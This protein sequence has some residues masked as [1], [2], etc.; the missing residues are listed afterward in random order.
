M[1]RIVTL[2]NC[3]TN[4]TPAFAKSYLAF[5]GLTVLLLLL[6]TYYLLPATSH[7]QQS[8]V[9]SITPG[10]GDL[11]INEE[12]IVSIS[13]NSSTGVSGFDLKF[14][15]SG[16]LLITDFR[17]QPSFDN[18]FDLFNARTV[19]REI[20]GSNSR[21]SYIFTASNPQ[22]PK[23]VTIYTKIK[24]QSGGEGKINLDYNNSQVLNGNGQPMQVIP[25]T[26]TYNLNPQQ[27][28]A[29]FIDLLTLPPV[30]YP[31]TAAVIDLKLKLAGS[32]INPK[33]TSIKALAVAVGRIGEGKYETQPQQFDLTADTDGTFS[34]KVAF[35]DFKDGNKFSLM[36]KV[37]KYLLKRICNLDPSEQKLGAYSCTEPA[38]TIR[39]GEANAF[40]FSKVSLL[41]GDLGLTDGVLNGYDLNIVRMNLN[42]NTP[43]AV[44]LADL[45]YDGM[46][47]QKDFDIINMVASNT[48]RQ[49]DQ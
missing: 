10:S 37:D 46:V 48:N 25:L 22:L 12:K 8:G 33:V 27:S 29:T 18:N 21:I 16:G 7:A 35:P 30:R 47:D 14:N 9:I 49:A 40:N 42:K 44:N 15:T 20:N 41:A 6:T 3:F 38:L 4:W 31:D 17:G 36:I 34:G 23:T 13:I 1:K 43:E 2:L 45:N 11:K 28:S 5:A 26:A 32:M 19:A 39:K 24:A